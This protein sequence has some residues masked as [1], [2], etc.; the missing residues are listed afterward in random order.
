MPTP[1]FVLSLR[2][3]IGHDLLW[4]MGVSGY[5]EDE[6]GRVL[7]G[8][9]SDTGEWAMVYGINEPGEE[10]ADTV[11][12]EVKEETGVEFTDDEAAFIALH[13][14]NAQLGGE[15]RDIYDMTYLLQAVFRIVYDEYGFRPDDE[16]LNYYRFVTHLKFYARRIVSGEGYG[17]EDSDL[18]D[19]VR[20]KYPKAYACADKIRVYVQRE[21]NFHSGQNELLYLTIHIA[22][23]MEHTDDKK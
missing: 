21:N 13:F 18:L 1:E 22:R 19:L 9:R 15:I 11:A 14:V 2:E 17:D 20:F 23:V 4:L 5:V 7:L 3:K 6:Q 12:R 10:P 8:R 16:S